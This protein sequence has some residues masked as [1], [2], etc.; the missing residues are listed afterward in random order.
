M[1]QL[2]STAAIGTISLGMGTRFMSAALSMS[3]I[4]LDQ[5]AQQKTV[6]A[7]PHRGVE[8]ARDDCNATV[9]RVWFRAATRRGAS[10]H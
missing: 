7:I 10:A 6:V 2:P 5:V 8:G 4:L 1:G 9:K 3:E